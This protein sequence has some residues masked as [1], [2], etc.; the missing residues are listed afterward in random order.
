ML[1]L[2]AGTGHRCIACSDDFL[3]V[4]AYP[5]GQEAYDVQRPDRTAHPR[6]LARIAKVPLPQQDPVGGIRGAL[7]TRWR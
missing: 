1:V 3:V 4:G 5:Q 2:P 6:A 7:M